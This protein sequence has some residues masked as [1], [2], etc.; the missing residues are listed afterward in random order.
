ML[1]SILIGVVAEAVLPG[2]GA[3]NQLF[4]LQRVRMAV[5]EPE[6][7]FAEMPCVRKVHILPVASVVVVEDMSLGLLRFVFRVPQ[8]NA[9]GRFIQM[10]AVAG[11]TIVWTRHFRFQYVPLQRTLPVGT[12][13]IL[14]QIIIITSQ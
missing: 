1:K 7:G 12:Q 2:Q 4:T 6:I 5:D 8:E 3:E 9:R 10:I 13:A 11:A 14:K